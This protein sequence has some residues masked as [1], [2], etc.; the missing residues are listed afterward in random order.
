M[1]MAKEENKGKNVI[2][3]LERHNILECRLDYFPK[4]D[5]LLSATQEWIKQG[6]KVH[7]RVQSLK[8]L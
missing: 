8:G 3:G 5:E 1:K 7:Y 4:A 2:V 6:Y